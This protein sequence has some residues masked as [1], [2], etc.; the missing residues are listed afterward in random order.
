MAKRKV[1]FAIVGLDHDHAYIHARM[2]LAAGAEFAAAYSDKPALVAEFRGI[3]PDVPVAR[4]MAEIL[5]DESIELIGGAAVPA[6]R[7]GISA[8]AMR[9]GKDVLADKPACVS[10]AQL[11]AIEKAQRETGRIWA[12]FTNEHHDRRCTVRAAELVRD[13]AIGKVIQTTGLGPHC[14]GAHVRPGWFLDPA[15]SAGIIG[16]IGAH[17]I[18]QFLQFT[19]STTAEV[20]SAFAGNGGHPEHPLF[21]DYG[22]VSLVGDGGRGW[23][24]VDWLSPKALNAPGDI[25]LFVLGTEGYIETRKYIDPSGRPGAEHLLLVNREGAR[26]VD[27]G[28]VALPFGPRLLNDVRDRTQTAIPQQRSFLTVRLAMQAQEM[29]A[30]LKAGRPQAA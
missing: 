6:E 19:G 25:R 23:F 20:V 27:V 4:S 16:D 28:N 26:F 3:Y 11:D 22:E 1:R 29:A 21:E 9:H 13:G 17:Q 7:A 14:F 8:S 2:L 24:R 12:F 5:E 10:K 30:R 18:E 15:T